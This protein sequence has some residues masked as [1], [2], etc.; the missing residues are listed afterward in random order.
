MTDSNAMLY[1]NDRDA[2][3]TALGNTLTSDVLTFNPDTLPEPDTLCI[4]MTRGE[5]RV[6]ESVNKAFGSIKRVVI[7]VD[8]ER[9]EFSA[10]ALIR[11]LEGLEGGLDD[12]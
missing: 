12:R 4:F 1:A 6:R 2:A 9:H 8:G 11:L 7:D 5:R 10:D 3:F